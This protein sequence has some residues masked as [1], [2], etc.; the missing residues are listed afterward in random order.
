MN[1][2]FDINRTIALFSLN[3]AAGRKAFLLAIAGFFGFVFIISF[4]VAIN[5]PM[6][7]ERMHYNFY[8]VLILGGA[9]A[10][11]GSA[12]HMLNTRQKSVSYLSLPASVA[13][14][15]LVSW[16]LSGIGWLM[17]VIIVYPFFALLIN[18]VWGS[19]MGFP[20]K[21]CHPLTGGCDL[22]PDPIIYRIYFSV[23]S[24]FFLG[25]AAFRQHPIPKTFLAGFIT[26]MIITVVA[27]LTTLALFGT[28]FPIPSPEA[29][30]SVNQDKL[31]QFNETASEAV[32]ILFL[33]LLPV[34]FY[35]AAFFK[36]K[37]REV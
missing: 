27:L 37:E 26:N 33:Y 36:L 2:I 13:E 15:F 4:F 34:V 29:I 11:G 19:I 23:H 17:F 31:D 3:L 35:V 5:N 9:M 14:K 32:K 24:L 12:F 28:F 18:S 25:A 7:L 30:E 8:H 20:I 22:Q 10:M 6:G 21:W 1:Q 16:I